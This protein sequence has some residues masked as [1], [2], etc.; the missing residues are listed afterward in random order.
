MY[1]IFVSIAPIFIIIAVGVIIALVRKKNHPVKSF[2]IRLGIRRD[3]WV[4]ILNK[5]ALWISL[6]ALITHSLIN[7][8][9]SALSEP[10]TFYLTT[11]LLLGTILFLLILTKV[12]K[13]NKKLSL[14]YLMCGFFGNVAYIGIPFLAELS[15]GSEGVVS[16]LVAIHVAIAFSIGVY[17]L[18]K[19]KHTRS[20]SMRVLVQKMVLNPLLLSTIIG[21]VIAYFSIPIPPV[22]DRAIGMVGASASP[23]VLIAVGLFLVQ[24]ISFGKDMKHALVITGLKIVVMPAIFL[25]VWFAFR[26]QSAMSLSVLEAGM[27]VALTNF[28][29]A[30]QYPMDKHV[31]AFAII[32]STVLSAF[33]LPLLAFF[34]S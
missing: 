33:S 9:R 25:A 22:I 5:Y 27:P 4:S 19:A 29:L 16:I 1:T 31:V 15:P 3:G 6:P 11:G 7:T 26:S 2:W 14:T 18:E 21:V 32:V 8:D 30:E 10:V 13:L 12:F 24:K 23:V 20:V 17:F 28:A 34:V